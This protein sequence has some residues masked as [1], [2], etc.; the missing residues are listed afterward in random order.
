AAGLPNP[1]ASWHIVATGDFNG[2]GK[3]D[4]LFQNTDGTPS[5]WEMNGTSIIGVG[6]LP[7]PSSSWHIV[8]PS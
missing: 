5:I 4:I 2:D 7:N 3:S 8:G 6:A 1:S